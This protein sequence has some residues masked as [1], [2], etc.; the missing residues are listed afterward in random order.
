MEYK[1][2]YEVEMCLNFQQVS[3]ILSSGSTQ[4]KYVHQHIANKLI[5]KQ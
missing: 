5:R 2:N 3:T 4:D 1:I